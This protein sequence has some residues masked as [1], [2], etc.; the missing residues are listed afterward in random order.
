MNEKQVVP[1]DLKI[2]LMLEVGSI[3]QILTVLGKE[4]HSAVNGLINDIMMQANLFIAQWSNQEKP[5]TPKE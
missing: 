1:S 3:N 4:P 5:S 2:P